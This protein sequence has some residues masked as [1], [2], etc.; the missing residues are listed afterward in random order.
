MIDM[1][2]ITAGEPIE[3][4]VASGSG[5][6]AGGRPSQDPPRARRL[7]RDAER[8]RQRV[9]RAAAEVFT[10][11]GL[12]AT[13]DD[14]ANHAGLGVGTVYRRFPNK[15]SLAEALFEEKIGALVTIA[16]RA[17][18]DPDSWHGLVSFLEQAGAML[19]H[20]RGLRQILMFATY[21][22]DRVAYGRERLLP[23]ATRLVERAQ[24]DGKL[25]ADIGPTDVPLIEFIVAS[26]SEYARDVRPGIWR[27]YLA[28][29]LDGLRPSREAATTLPET[30]LSPDEMT[31][32]MRSRPHE[33]R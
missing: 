29:I 6:A 23:R 15:E 30:A 32:A 4:D 17:L 28:L 19:A 20:D 21:G 31:Q 22:R 3:P 1:T 10:Q 14:V 8:N 27:R 25:R 2:S 24:R 26:A 7:R 11:R 18:A 5:A 13:L 12:E 33:R 16:D 9:L